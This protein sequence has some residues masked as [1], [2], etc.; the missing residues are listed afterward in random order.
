MSSLSANL[1]HY[2]DSDSHSDLDEKNHHL[3]P[4]KNNKKRKID[5]CVNDDDNYLQPPAKKQRKLPSL[6]SLSAK[7]FNNADD[8]NDNHLN[9]STKHQGRKRSFDHV[10][11]NWSVHIYIPINNNKVEKLLDNLSNIIMNET[12]NNETDNIHEIKQYHISLSICQSIKQYQI[13][14][15]VDSLRKLFDKNENKQTFNISINGLKFFV[16]DKKTRYFGS[17]LI[18]DGKENVI[19]LINVINVAMKN[20]GLKQYYDSPQPHISFIWSL[21]EFKFSDS[22]LIEWNTKIN[23]D[24]TIKVETIIIKIGH[25]KYILSIK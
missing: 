7:L 8:N 3:A 5:K 25:R 23:N 15:F 2:S 6:K 22:K 13:N 24:T 17:M 4:L 12:D 20:W 14:D 9:N 16:N 19:N 11:G 18:E 10:K 21:N 1:V